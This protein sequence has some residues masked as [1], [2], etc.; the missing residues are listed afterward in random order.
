MCPIVL[1]NIESHANIVA[2]L[3][4]S[5]FFQDLVNRSQATHML[6]TMQ[7]FVQTL[8]SKIITVNVVA[9]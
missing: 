7:L 6:K 2:E 1:H 5:M 9:L 8:T 4:F 3:R